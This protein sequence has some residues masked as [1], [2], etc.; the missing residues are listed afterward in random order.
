V[1]PLIQAL[2]DPSADVRLVAAWALG[3]I[4]DPASIDPLIE[5]LDDEDLYV[6]EM[7]VLA[8]GEIEDRSAAGALEQVFD[9]SPDLRAPAVWALGEIYE[10]TAEEITQQL[11]PRW[12]P[13]DTVSRDL[14]AGELNLR[15]RLSPRGDDIKETIELLL[16]GNAGERRNAAHA[17]G[18]MGQDDAYETLSSTIT[19]V[20]AL[21]VA[22]RDPEPA[23][24]AMATWALDE[25]NPSRSGDVRTDAGIREGNSRRK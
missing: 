20:D 2:D 17:L 19:A 22:L 18:T 15:R 6:R 4:K 7:V 10:V 21:L 11:D 24:R 14:W 8:L 12:T 16:N 25:I 5:A 1:E 13:S 3:E 23:V 9:D